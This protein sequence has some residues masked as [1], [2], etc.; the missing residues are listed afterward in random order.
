MPA[1]ARVPETTAA[2][3]DGSMKT[4]VNAEAALDEIEHDSNKLRSKEVREAIRQYICEQRR[5]I[6]ELRRFYN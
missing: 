5:A 6:K 2:L 3:R 4:L 1:I